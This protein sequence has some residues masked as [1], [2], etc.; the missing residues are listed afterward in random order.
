MK[1]PAG[2]AARLPGWLDFGKEKKPGSTWPWGQSAGAWDGKHSLVVWQRYHL[3]GEKRTNLENCDLIAARVDGFMSLDEA[4]VPIAA[5]E[6]EETKPALASDGA[7]HLLC[8]YENRSA[9]AGSRI[10]G[11]MLTMP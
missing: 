2:V 8:V 9:A 6:A 1:E 7:G 10:A 3:G 4:G 5:S 11:R